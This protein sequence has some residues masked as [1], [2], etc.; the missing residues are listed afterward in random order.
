MWIV[1]EECGGRERESGSWRRDV[2]KRGATVPERRRT[3]INSS[4]PAI[5]RTRYYRYVTLAESSVCWLM[6]GDEEVMMANATDIWEEERRGRDR[7]AGEERSFSDCITSN[8][9]MRYC[10][11][12]H[13]VLSTILSP[14]LV[15]SCFALLMYTSNTHTPSLSFSLVLLHS[16]LLFHPVM[17]FH[18]FL[19]S[20]WRMYLLQL[21]P[22]VSGTESG[23][24][25]RSECPP[26]YERCTAHRIHL[27]IIQYNTYIIQH[28]TI[29]IST[30]HAMRR[31]DKTRGRS[32]S[33]FLLHPQFWNHRT[34]SPH[35]EQWCRN[36]PSSHYLVLH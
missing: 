16:P 12:S 22:L 35:N 13:Q 24:L 7:G 29:P 3:D 23:T 11:M 14:C 17:C 4:C 10:T 5:I 25:L 6:T 31:Q 18:S 8:H 34:Q 21:H 33:L 36:V 28:T 26:A 32:S 27:N 1:R 30:C 15:L 19:L 2:R 20:R 9:I